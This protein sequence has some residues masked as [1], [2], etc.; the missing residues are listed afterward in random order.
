MKA[1]QCIAVLRDLNID[2]N[3]FSLPVP[4]VKVRDRGVALFDSPGYQKGI[5]V[6][7]FYLFPIC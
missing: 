3:L 1:I 2:T 7:A 4:R 6:A 5:N